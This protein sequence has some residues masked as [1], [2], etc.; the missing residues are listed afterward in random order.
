MTF[1]THDLPARDRFPCW[2]EMATQAHVRA[3]V[4]SEHENDFAATMRVLQLG[5]V[6]VSLLSYLSLQVTRTPRL[7]RENDPEMYLLNLNLNGAAGLT[8]RGRSTVYRA[9][10]FAFYGTSHPSRGWR[11][12][13][14]ES[15][16]SLVVQFPRALPGLPAA[17][18]DRL[19]TVPIC[20]WR[21]IGAVLAA[22][23]SQLVKDAD[24]YTEADEAA[25]AD[26]TLDLVAATLA[27]HLNA[28]DALTPETRRQV[29]LRRIDHFIERRLADPDLS[30]EVI[31]AAHHI[32]LRYL[33]RLFQ[34]RGGPTVG[35]CIREARLERCR[36]D[37]T[38]LRLGSLP[39]HMIAARWGFTDRTHFS[40]LFRSAYGV[41]PGDYRHT[42]NSSG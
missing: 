28:L 36:R 14:E 17:D 33:H 26:V 30:P 3:W 12:S 4:R 22:H 41:S 1:H 19:A 5:E 37:L 9:G 20:T 40:R 39:L 29:L 6:Q 2:F 13:Q 18:V 7:I 8:Y 21:G 42:W 15:A 24:G 11:S 32:S 38:D 16:R 23:L 34:A 31:A 10:E 25:L 35:A 27:H